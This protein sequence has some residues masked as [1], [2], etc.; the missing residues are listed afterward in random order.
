MPKAAKA[1]TTNLRD[2]I[3]AAIHAH[4]DATAAW[5]AVANEWSA[6]MSKPR[7]TDPLRAPEPPAG[8][9]DRLV[10][11]QDAELRTLRA[12]VDSRPANLEAAHA[13]IDYLGVV[14]RDRDQRNGEPPAGSAGATHTTVLHPVRKIEALVA[15]DTA[16]SEEVESLKRQLQG[17]AVLPKQDFDPPLL[18]PLVSA[19]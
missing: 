19:H 17:I 16:L 18:P 11:A 7:S 4:R 2:P 9:V 5:L 8:L 14:V 6:A 1:N 10:S 3:F 12:L 15:R 13:L